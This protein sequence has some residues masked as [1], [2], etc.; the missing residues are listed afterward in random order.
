MAADH[1]RGSGVDDGLVGSKTLGDGSVDH[2]DGQA[3][4]SV[5]VA[6]LDRVALVLVR[7]KQD[8]L[9]VADSGALGLLGRLGLLHPRRLGQR[10]GAVV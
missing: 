10:R 6:R 1:G 9:G 3:V 2:E 8:L 7:A 4:R 5:A